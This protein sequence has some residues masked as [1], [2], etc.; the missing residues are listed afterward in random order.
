MDVD[1]RPTFLYQ[2]VLRRDQKKAILFVRPINRQ[3]LLSGHVLALLYSSPRMVSMLH[4]A[5]LETRFMATPEKAQQP[6]NSISSAAKCKLLGIIN[7]SAI[8]HRDY[9]TRPGRRFL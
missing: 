9:S 7:T 3:S 1:G 6:Q 8:R 2:V 4:F 5:I